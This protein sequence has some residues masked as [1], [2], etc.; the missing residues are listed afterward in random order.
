[1]ALLA[2]VW[3]VTG[4][5]QPEGT[6]A[7]AESISEEEMGLRSASIYEEQV[8]LNQPL[9]YNSAAPGTAGVLPRSFENAPPMIPHSVEG[10]IPIT[11]NNNACVGCHM[12][13]MAEM[14][15]AVAIPASHLYD[16]RNDRDLGGKLSGSR[17]SCTQCHAPQVDRKPAVESRF[18]AAW[19]TRESMEG[20]NLMEVIGEGVE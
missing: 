8:A 12:P 6:S 16:L 5:T 2:A 18:E 4:C 15:G 1:M 9:S 10:L 11:A 20:S 13:E 3:M 17:Y 14:M 19:R 7:Q